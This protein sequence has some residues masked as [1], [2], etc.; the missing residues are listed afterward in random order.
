MSLQPV[1]RMLCT[2]YGLWSLSKHM[3]VLYQGGYCSGELP[4][5][6]IQDAILELC[7][8]LKDEAVSLVDAIAP[9]DFILNS[10]IAKADGELYRNLWSAVLQG[11]KVL[12]R[13]SWWAE[14]CSNKPVIGRLRSQL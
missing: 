2:L 14:F 7:T 1:L 12:E 6:I 5:K 10:P 13:P 4:G 11:E 3:A 9:P 8:Q